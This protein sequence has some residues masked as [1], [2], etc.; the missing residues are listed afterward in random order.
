MAGRKPL[1]EHERADELSVRIKRVTLRI[2]DALS[3]ATGKSRSEL[4]REVCEKEYGK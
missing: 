3:K 4:I 2:I 1:P